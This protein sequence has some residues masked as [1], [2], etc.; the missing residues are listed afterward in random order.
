MNSRSIEL[1][2]RVRDTEMADAVRAVSRAR[3]AVEQAEQKLD[4][5]ISQRDDFRQQV[6]A[7]FE[8]GVPQREMTLLHRQMDSFD[9]QVEMQ[10]RELSRQYGQLE[11]AREHQMELAMVLK[12]QERLEERLAAMRRSEDRARE[13]RQLDELG[14]Q[15]VYRWNLS[16]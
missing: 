13:Q 14:A 8:S 9:R 3:Q 1:L 10:R 7:Q 6:R 12:Q 4:Q 2:R 5:L 11:E 15:S 16:D